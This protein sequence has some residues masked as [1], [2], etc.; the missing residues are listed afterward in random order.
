LQPERQRQVNKRR[1]IEGIVRAL[2]LVGS[3]HKRHS[4]ELQQKFQITGPQLGVLRIVAGNP[5]ISLGELS[6]RIYLHISTVSSIVDRLESA[7]YL[8]RVRSEEDRRVVFL[9]LTDRGRAL[10]KRAPVYAFGFLMRDI[11]GLPAGEIHKIHSALKL[12]LKVMRIEDGGGEKRG[13]GAEKAAR[14]PEEMDHLIGRLGPNG[15]ELRKRARRFTG[16]GS[17]RGTTTGGRK[18]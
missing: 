8:A 16:K 13:G 18:R 15:G 7:G 12:L 14:A 1:E 9:S 2:R 10:A 17:T 5:R 3:V 6:Q 4:H 11:E